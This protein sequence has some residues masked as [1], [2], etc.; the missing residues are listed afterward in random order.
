M[1]ARAANLRLKANGL[2]M[3]A[4]LQRV[5]VRRVTPL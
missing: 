3:L 4:Y 5:C 1:L 2:E